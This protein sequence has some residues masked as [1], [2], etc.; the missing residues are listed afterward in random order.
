VI[1]ADSGPLFATAD[2]DDA[3]HAACAGL[4]RARYAELVVPATVVVEVC[5]LI[6][7]SLGPSAEA[8]FLRSAARGNVRVETV[9]ADDYERMAELVETYADLRLGMVDASV[10]AVAERLKVSTVLT[11]NRRDFT[12]VRP[13]HVEAFDLLP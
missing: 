4:V 2:A 10:V 3:H 5:W 6:E 8:G 11:V 12:V 7:R 13:R 1:V 9:T